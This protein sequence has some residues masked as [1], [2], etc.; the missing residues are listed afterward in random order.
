MKD[1]VTNNNILELMAAG[2]SREQAA[3]IAC[4]PSSRGQDING[5]YEVKRNPLSKVG[6]F[7]YLGR[8]IDPSGR[9]GLDPEKIYQV[10]RPAEE[11]AD[12]ECIDSFK[13]IPWVVGHAMLGSS[14]SGYLPAEQ[15]GIHGVIGE[16]VF[17]ENDTLYGNIK[18]FSDSMDDRIESGEKELSAGYRCVYEISSGVYEGNEYHVIQRRIRGNH[19]AL[20]PEGRMGHEVAVLDHMNFTFDAKDIQMLKSGTGKDQEEAPKTEGEGKKEMSLE[21]V[22]AAL[23]SL[24]PQVQQLMSFMS[25]LKPLEEAEHGKTLDKETA[26]AAD[27][28]EKDDEAEKEKAKKDGEAMDAAEQVKSLSAQVESLKRDGLKVMLGEIA[29]RDSLAQ[30]LSGFVGTFD[31]ADK[32]LGEVAKYGVEKLGIKCPAGQEVTAVEA[33]LTGRPAPHTTKGFALDAATAPKGGEIAAY[34]NGSK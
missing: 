28:D 1:E 27:Q 7:P 21:Q 11:L 4:Q 10:Y 14:G 5:W 16:S 3:A 30:R 25:K 12:P 24:A 17:F 23:E 19:L 13:L 6:V 29:Q 22:V 33:Y 18:W 2:Y 26:T 15:K 8:S 32:T 34:L 20:V 9:L 31:H